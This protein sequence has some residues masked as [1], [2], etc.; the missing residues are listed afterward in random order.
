MLHSLCKDEL[1]N[2]VKARIKE[3][4]E[5]IKAKQNLLV[6]IRPEFKDS[7][8]TTQLLDTVSEVIFAE[9]IRVQVEGQICNVSARSV[10]ALNMKLKQIMNVKQHR[11]GNS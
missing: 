8:V 4:K 7:L 1:E 6:E 2:Y 9:N 3:R 10:V 5:T 11:K